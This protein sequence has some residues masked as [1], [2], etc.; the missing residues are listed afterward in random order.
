M[1]TF[2]S[3]CLC[4]AS[5]VPVGTLRHFSEQARAKGYSVSRMTAY[6]TSVSVSHRVIPNR[7]AV[8]VL[9]GWAD[10]TSVYYLNY[11][12]RAAMTPARASD[13]L[14]SWESRLD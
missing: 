10:T 4:I 13:L 6:E 11:D 7:C 8:M 12:R 9:P 2:I 3:L 14:V 5:T 1:A